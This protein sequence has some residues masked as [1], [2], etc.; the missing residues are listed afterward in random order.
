LR[1][2]VENVSENINVRSIVGR[3][4]EHTRVFYFLNDSHQQVYLS[5]ADWMGRNFFNRVETCFMVEDKRLRDRVIKQGLSNYLNDNTRAWQLRSDGTYVRVKPGSS[6]QRDAQ[7]SL[8]E[9][10]GE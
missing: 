10:L 3:F 5:S 6:R 9:H 2:G 1:P 4:L 8:L 7:Q